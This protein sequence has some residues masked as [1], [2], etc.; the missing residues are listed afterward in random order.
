[1]KSMKISHVRYQILYVNNTES[2]RN[3][4]NVSY[5]VSFTSFQFFIF[6]SEKISKK[7]LRGNLPVLFIPDIRKKI[8]C[9][10]MTWKL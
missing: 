10:M 6:N 2:T 3:Q 7:K 1:M 8:L 4:L 5:D 9:T